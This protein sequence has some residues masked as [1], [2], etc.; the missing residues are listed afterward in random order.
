LKTFSAQKI[1]QQGFTLIELMIVVAIVGI[2]A[3]IALPAY[4]NYM[5]K[6]KLVEVTGFLDAQKAGIAE[7]WATYQTTGFQ[8]ASPVPLTKPSNAKY[9]S[10]VNYTTTA[11]A[12]AAAIVVTIASNTGAAALNGIG[13]G[14]IA[15]GLGDGSVSWTCGT[16]GTGTGSTSFSGTTSI[17]PYLP[18]TCQH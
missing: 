14:L 6:S 1:A 18:S 11:S 9:I 7:Y 10:A 3:A 12:S 8:P 4:Q 5:I 2:L 16:F 17:Y 13:I 15:S